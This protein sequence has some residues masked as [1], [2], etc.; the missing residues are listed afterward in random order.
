MISDDIVKQSLDIYSSLKFRSANP[1]QYTIFASIAL[2]SQ[3][4]SQANLK[5]VSLATGVKCLPESRFSSNGDTIHDCHAEILAR[6]GFIRW[7]LEEVGRTAVS[8]ST[9]STRSTPSLW[10]E[11]HN[12]GDIRKWSLKK[13]LTLHLYISTIPCL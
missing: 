6:R 7:L 9:S 3:N 4:S 8:E 12:H 11:R 2:A 5:V 13:G 1:N 10:I